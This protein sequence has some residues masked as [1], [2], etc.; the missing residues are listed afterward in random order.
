MD[1]RALYKSLSP[2]DRTVYQSIRTDMRKVYLNAHTN[3][4][5]MNNW[6]NSDDA[7]L[8]LIDIK[9]A[10]LFDRAGHIE[11]VEPVIEADEA[12]SIEEKIEVGGNAITIKMN[13]EMSKGS[14]ALKANGGG[15]W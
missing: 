9:L 8:D 1:I 3:I 4:V 6:D 5:G 11:G 7:Y 13:T 15:T 14:V 10:M 12:K 2:E